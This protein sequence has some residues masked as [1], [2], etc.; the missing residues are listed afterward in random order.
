VL[1][2]S[3]V[4]DSEASHESEGACQCVSSLL[5]RRTRRVPVYSLTVTAGGFSSAP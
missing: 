3:G 1:G 4:S 5:T 2:T